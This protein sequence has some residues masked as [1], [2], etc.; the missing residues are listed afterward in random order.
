[1]DGPDPELCWASPRRFLYVGSKPSCSHKHG[2]QNPLT[3][4]RTLP[5]F[6]QST[7]KATG[8]CQLPRPL[9]GLYAWRE[10]ALL[11]MNYTYGHA[12]NDSDGAPQNAPPFLRESSANYDAAE[13]VGSVEPSAAARPLLLCCETDLSG[14][15]SIRTGRP[16]TVTVT[17]KTTD[18]LTGTTQHSVRIWYPVADSGG[19]RPLTR[20]SIRRRSRYRSKE[21]G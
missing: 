13:P 18:V 14:V 9:A 6:D 20:G 11:G 3:G 12:I 8:S 4:K 1:M 19:R 10:T 15:G 16:L 5:N 17:R 7:T 21:P 2:Q